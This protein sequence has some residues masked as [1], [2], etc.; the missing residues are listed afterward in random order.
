MA[1][2]WCRSTGRKYVTETMISAQDPSYAGDV[3]YGKRE[4]DC[5]SGGASAPE[6]WPWQASRLL[7]VFIK[8][9]HTGY[10]D[11]EEL[12]VPKQIAAN[13]YEKPGMLNRDE[14]GR[15][16]Y[17]VFSCLGARCGRAYR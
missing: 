2:R 7:G 5:D 1:G 11:W 16:C 13:P 9:H 8:Y 15:H 6:L 3:L 14:V 17:L 12:S 10:G 4:A